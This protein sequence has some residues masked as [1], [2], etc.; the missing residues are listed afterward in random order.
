M[1]VLEEAMLG[2]KED[3]FCSREKQTENKRARI[4]TASVVFCC[5]ISDESDM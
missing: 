4:V 2:E 1:N 3:A 5:F